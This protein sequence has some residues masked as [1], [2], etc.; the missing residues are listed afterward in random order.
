MKPIINTIQVNRDST[1]VFDFITNSANVEAIFEHVTHVV[2]L[3]KQQ[4]A[5]HSKYQQTR[6]LHGQK[7]RETVEVVGYERNTKYMLRVLIFGVETLYTY[8]LA[9]VGDRATCV[10]L[11]KEA[12]GSGLRRLL[13]PLIQH[14]LTQSEHDG[15]HLSRLK[16]A[17]ERQ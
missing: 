5:V 13:M 8:T 15:N 16:S 4:G 6:R 11:T 17:V 9:P 3:T 14:V 2:P 7:W 10:H 1:T 12:Q